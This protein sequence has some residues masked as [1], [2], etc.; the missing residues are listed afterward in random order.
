MFDSLKNMAGL[1]GMMKDLPKIKAR[2]EE[3]RQQLDTMTV[4]AES[5]GGAVRATATGSLRITGIE[6]EPALLSG[7]VD[8]NNPQD[9][10]L[11]SDLI[12]AAVNAALTKARELAERT[13]GEAAGD[14]GIPLPSGGLGGML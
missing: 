6:I 4:T 14:L 5:G 7:L 1:A 8:V 13:L 12:A 11:A 10:E 2:F 3:V 9:S